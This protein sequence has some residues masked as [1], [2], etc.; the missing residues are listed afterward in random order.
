MKADQIGFWRDGVLVESSISNEEILQILNKFGIGTLEDVEI[1]PPD[2]SGWYGNVGYYIES[3][4][5]QYQEIYTTAENDK[6]YT[7]NVRFSSTL[8][9][10]ISPSVKESNS[11]LT[12][13]VFLL[14]GG[15]KSRKEI[16]E[17]LLQSGV[18]IKKAKVVYYDVF[19]DYSPEEREQLL[20]ELN[21][22]SHILFAFKEY[23]SG[24]IC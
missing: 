22:D 18:S 9:D 8:F 7:F 2:D 14:S 24:D 12:Y 4:E 23:M 20:S 10:L 1:Y 3:N 11:T 13:P 21:N 15:N 5:S 19:Y 16:Y 17:G 6:N